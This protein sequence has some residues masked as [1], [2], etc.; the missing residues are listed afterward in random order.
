LVAASERG[1]RP[2]LE[3][4]GEDASASGKEPQVG[5]APGGGRRST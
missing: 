2:E 5:R 1:R 3:P 4:S